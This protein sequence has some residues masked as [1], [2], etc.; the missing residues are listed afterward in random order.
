MNSLVAL[1]AAL[2]AGARLALAPRFTPETFWDEIR[3]AGATVV[4]CTGELCR[5]LVQLEP[6]PGEDRH[7]VRIFVGHDVQPAVWHQLR[8]RFGDL[9]LLSLT[10]LG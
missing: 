9:E 1:G 8:E 3:R 2:S 4:P 6:R 7:P 10:E 5:A